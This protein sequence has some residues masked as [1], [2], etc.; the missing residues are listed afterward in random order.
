MQYKIEKLVREWRK[1][2]GIKPNILYSINWDTREVI[3]FTHRPGLMV[4]KAG[5]LVNKYNEML[6]ER[7]KSKWS[8]TFK[9]CLGW[10]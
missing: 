5:C 10:A 4:G 1:E 9:E 2:A 6:C 7:T 8:F 3:I